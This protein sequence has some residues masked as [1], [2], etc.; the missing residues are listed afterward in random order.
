MAIRNVAGRI[1]FALTADNRGF[2]NAMNRSRTTISAT[3]KR[4]RS[5]QKVVRSAG[6]SFGGAFAAYATIQGLRRLGDEIREVTSEAATLVETSRR[7]DFTAERLQL[8]GR[9]VEGEGGSQESLIKGLERFARGLAEA[10]DGIGEYSEAYDEL[11]VSTKNVFGETRNAEDVFNDVVSALGRVENSADRTR[12]AY[13]IFGRSSK[14]L[15]NVALLG[16]LSA[17]ESAFRKINVITNQEAEDLKR[18]DQNFTDL[19]NSI[20]QAFKRIIVSMEGTLNRFVT[21]GESAAKFAERF[22]GPAASTTFSFLHPLEDRELPGAMDDSFRAAA[23][24]AEAIVGRMNRIL[25]LR[26]GAPAAPTSA[27]LL[28]SLNRDTTA[29]TPEDRQRF[30]DALSEGYAKALDAIRAEHDRFEASLVQTGE[31]M[32]SSRE[33]RK[34]E[35]IR[36]ELDLQEQIGGMVTN[37]E[38]VE[39]KIIALGDTSRQIEKARAAAA[40]ALTDE[41]KKQL[42][43]YVKL[44][45]ARRRG[46][47]RVSTAGGTTVGVEMISAAIPQ[48]L[49]EA[50]QRYDEILV[51]IASKTEILGEAGERVFRGIGGSIEQAILQTD[52]WGEALER[53]G[54]LLAFRAIETFLDPGTFNALFGG[55]ANRLRPLDTAAMGGPI[56]A[57]M[58]T[59][60]GEHGPEILTPDRNS[61]I[62]PNGQTDKAT[63]GNTYNY[64]SVTGNN[65]VQIGRAGRR[66]SRHAAEAEEARAIHREERVMPLNPAP[67]IP[68]GGRCRDH[69]P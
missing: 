34:L 26:L 33:D 2:N 53:I 20:E 37:R 58:P 28:A 45:E 67:G 49:P 17:Q 43:E 63:G 50:A 64:F 68:S 4:M 60:V 32:L 12:L 61:Y 42:E 3:E 57:G 16:N 66:S 30:A 10:A 14:A 25:D 24:R 54:R 22:A 21:L 6:R 27:T 5:F 31:T 47:S 9:V 69:L 46:Q 29:E 8:L 62:I 55:A 52:S 44:L 65:P 39:A 35:G 11:G 41:S 1:W 36:A 19:G 38:R 51:R 56:Y 15:V 18:L 13:D 7:L 40:G 48:E 59:L 23:D